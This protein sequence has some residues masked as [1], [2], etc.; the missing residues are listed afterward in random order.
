[1]LFRKIVNIVILLGICLPAWAGERLR[2]ATEGAYPPFNFIDENGQLAG[3]DVDIAKA[4]CNVLKAECEISAVPWDQLLTDLAAGRCDMV[5]AS[6][7]E[8]PERV[9]LAEFTNPYYRTPNAFIGRS[10][11]G[12]REVTPTTA[13][14]KVLAAQRDTIQ[15]TYLQQHYKDVAELKLTDTL[16]AAFEALA[17]GEVDFVL[18]DALLSYSFINSEIR[19]HLE[20]IGNTISDQELSSLSFIQVR[21]GNLKLRDAIN[22]A[23]RDIK[24]DGIY[25]QINAKYFPLD[26]Y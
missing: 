11:N 15:G 6:M 8:T 1:M 17:R 14:G 12:V 25:R 22:Q 5:V 10:D 16:P 3:F 18:A 2:V 19:Q 4:L 7:A 21:K 26:I 20:I 23:L 24:S 9:Q 13:R